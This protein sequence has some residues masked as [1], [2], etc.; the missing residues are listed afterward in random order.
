M[1]MEPTLAWLDFSPAERERTNRILSV[2]QERETRDEL[3]LGA[4]RDSFSDHLFP[5]TS[6][7]QTRLR[8]MFFVPWIYLR[9]E[10]QRIPS[11]EIAARARKLELDLTN[12]LL[13]EDDN[14]G[15]F[16]R[17]AKGALQRLPSAVYWAG[18]RQYGI[19][20]YPGG[21]EDY[22]RDLDSIYRRRDRARHE[23]DS[24]RELYQFTWHP[25]LPPAPSDFL[26]H[27]TFRLTSEEAL[28]FK[29]CL[30]VCC[31]GSLLTFLAW[32]SEA[33]HVEFP[34][35]H[36]V[37]ASFSDAHREMLENARL[38]SMVAHGAAILYNLML[39]EAGGR[40]ELAA[41]YRDLF[42]EWL[43][44][45]GPDRRRLRDWDLRRF[46]EVARHP[47]HTIASGARE[48]VEF[49]T[50]LSIAGGRNLADRDDA[51]CLIRNRESRLKGLR[52]RFRNRRALEQWGGAAGLRPLSYRWHNA[53][54]FLVDLA[55]G[56]KN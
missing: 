50:R 49:W 34:W 4:I 17:L 33:A 35:E 48:F 47:N 44:D 6:T 1:T 20:T 21:R 46:W 29:D 31:P 26:E 2:I 16:G 53:V 9:L 28:F 55:E 52:S 24:G 14:A 40:D 39:A 51:R 10:R 56:L 45:I 7:I 18:L 11:S 36:P 30:M 15:V 37:L 22:H 3:G 27:P 12:P 38:F 41:D 13:A 54:T 42:R 19:G 43:D 23:S 32:H 8:S 5:G 25:K